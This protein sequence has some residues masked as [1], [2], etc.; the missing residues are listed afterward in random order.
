MIRGLR[1]CTS[2]YIAELVQKVIAP[3]PENGSRIVSEIDN[4]RRL[5][6]PIGFSQVMDTMSSLPGFLRGLQETTTTGNFDSILV[7]LRAELKER[8]EWPSLI[9]IERRLKAMESAAIERPGLSGASNMDVTEE[10]FSGASYSSAASSK[11]EDE[12]GEDETF[13]DE[14]SGEERY[15]CSMVET[16]RKYSHIKVAAYARKSSGGAFPHLH[17][18]HLA[19]EAGMDYAV[20]NAPLA[21]V[22]PIST[23]VNGS[24][25]AV[26]ANRQRNLHN[27]LPC[28]EGISSYGQMNQKIQQAATDPANADS[29]YTAYLCAS[30]HVVHQSII[31]DNT[32]VGFGG[33]IPP[34]LDYS[35]LDPNVLKRTYLLVVSPAHPLGILVNLRRFKETLDECSDAYAQGIMAMPRDP[36]ILTYWKDCYLA[37]TF[38]DPHNPHGNHRNVIFRHFVQNQKTLNWLRRYG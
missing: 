20:L 28:N 2:T 4:W 22:D 16:F 38:L 31:M 9:I 29:R 10:P 18:L 37:A 32:S 34:G 6:R 7:A 36:D 33:P 23:E 25:A 12:L 27:E 24:F 19:L 17:P 30:N 11:E 21:V 1:V 26:C 13:V 14:V 5:E 3:N 35:I 8:K 15:S